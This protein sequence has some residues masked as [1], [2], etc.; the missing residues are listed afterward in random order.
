MNNEM[1][2]RTLSLT[3]LTTHYQ[4][5]WKEQYSEDFKNDNWTK[6]DD[7]RLNQNFFFKAHTGGV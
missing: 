1:I 2:I 5:L 7:P 3:C 4:E 6:K